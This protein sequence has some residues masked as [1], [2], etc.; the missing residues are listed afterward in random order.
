V[1][2][3][4]WQLKKIDATI[5]GAIRPTPSVIYEEKK[6]ERKINC[7]EKKKEKRRERLINV[8]NEMPQ[9]DDE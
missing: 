9:G 4:L 7:R 3:F 1:L 5:Q 6:T 8:D 2:F